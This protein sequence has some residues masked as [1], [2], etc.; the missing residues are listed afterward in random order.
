MVVL[1]VLDT[2]SSDC[3][4]VLEGSGRLVLGLPVTVGAGA[5]LSSK[6]IPIRTDTGLGNGTT[7]DD[8]VRTLGAGPTNWNKEKD[9]VTSV[10]DAVN[11]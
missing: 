7:E 2:T 4:S 3:D 8:E 6:F 10:F 1:A 5:G 11:K 9:H